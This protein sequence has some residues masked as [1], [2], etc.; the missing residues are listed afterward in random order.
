MDTLYEDLNDADSRKL[1]DYIFNDSITIRLRLRNPSWLQFVNL[2]NS[3]E[4][5]IEYGYW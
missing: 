5:V 2:E 1:L 4:E 3:E